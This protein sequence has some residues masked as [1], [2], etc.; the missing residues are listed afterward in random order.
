MARQRK[1]PNYLA[2]LNNHF[3]GGAALILITEILGSLFNMVIFDGVPNTWSL[4][5]PILSISV[6]FPQCLDQYQK[7][8][9]SFQQSQSAQQ[10]LPEAFQTLMNHI[11]PYSHDVSNQSK[12]QFVVGLNKFVRAVSGSCVRPLW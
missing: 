8:L 4:A 2:T 1:P 9:S 11:T 7:A 12:E 6:C 10:L 5:R 3:Q